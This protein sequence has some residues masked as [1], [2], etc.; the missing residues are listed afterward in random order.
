MRWDLVAEQQ[1][2]S[3]DL[4]IWNLEIDFSEGGKLENSEKTLEAQ[5]EQN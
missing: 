2:G 3:S 4:S 5:I 1:S